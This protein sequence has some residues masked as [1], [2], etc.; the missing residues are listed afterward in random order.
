[1]RMR[2]ASLRLRWLG[3]GGW[4]A[5]WGGVAGA[6]RERSGGRTDGANEDGWRLHMDGAL[7]GI[8]MDDR[9]ASAGPFLYCSRDFELARHPILEYCI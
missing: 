8:C 7:L 1:M 6:R 9:R 2:R 5:G 3:V 4:G